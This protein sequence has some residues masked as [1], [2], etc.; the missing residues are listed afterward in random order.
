MESSLLKSAISVAPENGKIAKTTAKHASTQINLPEELAEKLR[1]AVREVIP[2]SDLMADGYEENLHVTTKYGVKESEDDLVKAVAGQAAFVVELGKTHVFDPSESSD[3]AAPVAVL[4]DAPE[5]HELHTAIDKAMGVKEDS[6]PDYLPHVCL[7]YVKPE[8]ASKYEGLDIFK[9]IA[10]EADSITISKKDRVCVAVPFGKAK[11]AASDRGSCVTLAADAEGFPPAV[12]VRF[13]QRGMQ[14]RQVLKIVKQIVGEVAGKRVPWRDIRIFENP[15]GGY[16]E[17]Q[18]RFPEWAAKQKLVMYDIM[19]DGSFQSV[20]KPHAPL[21]I[22]GSHKTPPLSDTVYENPEI[23]QETNAYADIPERVKGVE[24]LPTLEELAPEMFE[25]KAAGFP[26][27]EEVL[28]YGGGS[29]ESVVNDLVD[30]EPLRKKVK[31]LP[32]AEQETALNKLGLKEVTRR[33]KQ[34]NA[35][36]QSHKFPLTVYRG[37][38]A[39]SAKEV[40]T[41]PD[42]V[43]KESITGRGLGVYWAYDE[44]SAYLS[45]ELLHNCPAWGKKGIIMFRAVIS[46]PSKVD[47]LHTAWTNLAAEDEKE[48][49]LVKGARIQVTG[50]KKYGETTWRNP[51]PRFRSV[52]AVFAEAQ[53]QVQHTDHKPVGM[54]KTP[55]RDPFQ[56]EWDLFAPKDEPEAQEPETNAPMTPGGE[57]KSLLNKAAAKATYVTLWDLVNIAGGPLR[58]KNQCKTPEEA[59]ALLNDTHAKYLRNLRT[60]FIG[61]HVV[62]EDPSRIAAW[63]EQLY[64]EN[65]KTAA[66]LHDEAKHKTYYHGTDEEARAQAILKEGI[67]PREIILPNKA[68]SRAM[69]APVP[70][71]VYL[72]DSFGYAA[73]YALGG[74]AFGMGLSDRTKTNYTADMWLKN[75]IKAGEYGY[76]FEVRGADLAGDVVPDEDSIGEALAWMIDYKK[77]TRRL[78]ELE[79]QPERWK[80]EKEGLQRGLK[81]VMEQPIAKAPEDIQNRLAWLKT[82][83][84]PAQLDR[85]DEAAVQ[86]Q[87]GKKLQKRLPPDVAEWLLDHGAHVAHQGPV[88]PDRCWRFGKKDAL[89]TT[90]LQSILQEVPIRKIA[91]AQPVAPVYFYIEVPRW[92]RERFCRLHHIEEKDKYDV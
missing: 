2:E 80:G 73:I 90:D 51:P 63:V 18:E 66:P 53:N 33:W 29:V 47:W 16:A 56:E 58:I 23:G 8:A 84:T 59:L 62:P 32:E 25:K 68:K 88:F 79:T 42:F 64:S 74:Q 35:L 72:T 46:D 1:E 6:F 67:Q 41:D 50:V 49:H 17:Q 55:K 27:L 81:A 26:S 3:G 71:R 54:Y 9:G 12:V 69:Q 34:V 7:A 44:D 21:A 70:D 86:S 4:V 76:I 30:W 78:E 65:K 24:A 48:V 45:K 77:D 82:Y 39:N 36:M 10:F 11:T 20:G 92:A 5:L 19:P 43:S 40:V 60:K 61:M 89:Y 87:V 37:V 75:H 57:I 85:I 52:T 15:W 14:W 28:E 13:P 22:Q 38:C 31:N 91:A 83:L